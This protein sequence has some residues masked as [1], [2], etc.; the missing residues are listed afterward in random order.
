MILSLFREKIKQNK[1]FL[2]LGYWI[3]ECTQTANG[4][5]TRINK[6]RES[7]CLQCAFSAKC[8]RYSSGARVGFY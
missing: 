6:S 2:Q 4:V 1:G 5:A 3:K 8:S 7:F